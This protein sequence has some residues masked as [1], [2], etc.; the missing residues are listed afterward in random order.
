[1]LQSVTL[2]SRQDS[3]ARAVSNWC[4]PPA[5]IT[6]AILLAASMPPGAMLIGIQWG[7]GLAVLVTG[8]P[9]LYIQTL[10]LRGEVS[11]AHLQHRTE[12]YRPLLVSLLSTGLAV[13][14]A[15]FGGA[16]P[17][18]ARLLGAIVL[19]VALLGITTFW[20]QISFHG[21]AI[22]LA[23]ILAVK[24]L[25]SSAAPLLLFIPLVGWARCTLGRH[26]RWQVIMGTL[27]GI[28]M[29]VWI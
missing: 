14:I 8:L 12:R 16:P 22:A 28:L 18:L 15:R 3:L 24:L 27:L 29:A 17:L 1:M 26:T 13:V 9:M 25:G 4:S 23:T 7:L 20:W 2:H 19:E 5:M 21:A 6:A 11:D 10:V